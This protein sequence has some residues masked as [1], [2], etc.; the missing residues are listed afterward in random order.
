MHDA[1]R[2]TVQ[3]DQDI[4][5]MPHHGLFSKALC[6]AMTRGIGNME[7]TEMAAI[8]GAT[9]PSEIFLAGFSNL[10]AAIS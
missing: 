5:G 4:T 9:A 8:V 3:S 7:A 10:E 1:D 6:E 2:V